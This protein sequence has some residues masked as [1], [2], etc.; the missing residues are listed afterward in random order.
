MSL[1]NCKT[2]EDLLNKVFEIYDLKSKPIEEIMI[3][4]SDLFDLKS[5]KLSFLEKAYLNGK[6]ERIANKYNI[7]K[8]KKDGN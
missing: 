1:Y 8:I 5:K 3:I 6:I 4:I 2:G 7:R